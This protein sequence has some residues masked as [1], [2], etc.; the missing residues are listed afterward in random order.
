MTRLLWIIG[1]SIALLV[2]GGWT[3]GIIY[4][5]IS[6]EHLNSRGVVMLIFNGYVAWIT[7]QYL[8]QKICEPRTPV[9][10]TDSN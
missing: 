3:I 8:I 10:S 1:L 2:Y 5:G 6:R 4:A 7:L 9:S